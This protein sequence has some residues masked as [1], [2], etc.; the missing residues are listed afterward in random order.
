MRRAM[1][2]QVL[3]IV[4]ILVISPFYAGVQRVEAIVAFR[5]G[6]ATAQPYCDPLKWLC[7]SAC[8]V[9]VSAIALVITNELLPLAFGG[10]AVHDGRSRIT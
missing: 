9:A 3:Q 2:L 6:P 7:K 4:V 8:F 5:P 1:F 10:R